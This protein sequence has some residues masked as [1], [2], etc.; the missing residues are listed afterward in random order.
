MSFFCIP[1]I[2]G[3]SEHVK[4]E[5]SPNPRICPRCHNA[6]VMSAKTRTWFSVCFLP[7]IPLNS[8]HIWTCAICNWNVPVQQG[9]E[10]L[11]PGSGYQS[12]QGMPPPGGQVAYQPGYQPGYMS[13][14]ASQPHPK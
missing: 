10:P 1:I 8:N 12:P 11:V 7:L 6:S 3:C 5:G 2:F 14:P 9:W 4:P 13:P